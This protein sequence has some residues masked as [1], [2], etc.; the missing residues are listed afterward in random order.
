MSPVAPAGTHPPL[1]V[2]GKSADGP[3]VDGGEN[4]IDKKVAPQPVPET[5]PDE[6]D[7]DEAA[8]RAAAGA[9]R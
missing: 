7:E 9:G 5:E 4:I 2:H 8:C 6:P 1:F 3:G